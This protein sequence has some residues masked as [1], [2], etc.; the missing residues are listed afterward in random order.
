MIEIFFTGPGPVGPLVLC[1]KAQ[2]NKHSTHCAPPAAI[3]IN[4]HDK[5]AAAVSACQRI[6]HDRNNQA[7]KSAPQPRARRQG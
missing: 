2:N 3:S 6:Q 1:A 5:A 4:P 7:A